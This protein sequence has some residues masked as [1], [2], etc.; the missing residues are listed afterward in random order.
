MQSMVPLLP[1][2]DALSVQICADNGDGILG[3]V[4][5]K[6]AHGQWLSEQNPLFEKAALWLQYDR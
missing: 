3:L 2:T 5:L 1:C 6:S 4:E